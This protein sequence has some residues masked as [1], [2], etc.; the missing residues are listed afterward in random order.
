[1]VG[2]RT[3]LAANLITPAGFVAKSLVAAIDVYLT[4]EAESHF[5]KF[6]SLK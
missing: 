1:M 5:R 6:E 3:W 2:K 4:R